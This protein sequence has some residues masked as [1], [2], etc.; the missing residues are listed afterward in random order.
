MRMDGRGRVGWLRYDCADYIF[1]EGILGKE[2][3]VLIFSEKEL[4][5]PENELRFLRMGFASE[6]FLI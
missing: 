2:W 6:L 1:G 4:R 3:M 5:S